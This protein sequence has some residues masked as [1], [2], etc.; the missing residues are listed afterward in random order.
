M[1]RRENVMSKKGKQKRNSISTKEGKSKEEKIQ[2]NQKNSKQMTQSKIV[3]KSDCKTN[4][5][6]GPYS[7]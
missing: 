5:I 1:E 3:D 2:T 7:R 6:N 4:G